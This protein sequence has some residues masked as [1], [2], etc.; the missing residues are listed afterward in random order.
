MIV[1]RILAA[2]IPMLVYSAFLY[3]M[4]RY[5]KEPLPLLAAAFIWGF[6]PAGILSLIAQLVFGIPFVLVDETGALADV[7]GAVVLAPFTEEIFK[8]AAVFLIFLLWR[9]EFD[10]LF[11]GIIYGGLVGFGFAAVENILY[12]TL[13]YPGDL[14]TIIVRTFVFGL[15]HAL[16]TS[17]TGIGFGIARHARSPAGRFLSPL[18][19]LSAAIL[20]HF[21]HNA[22][23]TFS[24]EYPLLICLAFLADWGGVF[25]VLLV[26]ILAIRRERQWIID[27]LAEEVSSGTL[28]EDL[29][30]VVS[31]PLKRFSSRLSALASQGPD[32]WFRVGRQH[33]LL[34]ELAYKKHAFRRQGQ[35]AGGQKAIDD[36]RE[37]ARALSR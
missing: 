8:G 11:D 27:Q 10:S 30:S 19:G 1:L 28:S 26:M 14:G 37:K 33:R 17:L 3:W 13:Y 7:A 16:F 15:N 32:E 6:I 25:F 31:S 23:I 29:Y 12:F 34:T 36:L 22:S 9:S 5:E 4:D 20:A 35:P 2:V 24:A 18:A 21:L